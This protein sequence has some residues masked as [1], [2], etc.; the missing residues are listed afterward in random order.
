MSASGYA[1]IC[2][3][4]LWNTVLKRNT[5]SVYQNATSAPYESYRANEG[6]GG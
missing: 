1:E 6:V 5:A 4:R 3:H 2:Q